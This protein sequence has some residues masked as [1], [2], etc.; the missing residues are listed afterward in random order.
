MSWG[1]RR[2]TVPQ[3]LGHTQANAVPMQQCSTQ[4][5]QWGREGQT[6]CGQTQALVHTQAN[7]VTGNTVSEGKTHKK[8]THKTAVMHDKIEL[9]LHGVLAS[10]FSPRAKTNTN[11]HKIIN[12]PQTQKNTKNQQ[13]TSR[14]Q[15]QNKFLKLCR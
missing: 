9:R 5:R 4:G 10:F 3:V 6:V 12:W 14:V 1:T 11:T 8:L 7:A 15:S 13:K 2:Q